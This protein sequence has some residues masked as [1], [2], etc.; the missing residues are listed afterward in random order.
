MINYNIKRE[1]IEGLILSCFLNQH[2]TLE[3]D[4]MEF[5]QYKLP[6]ELFKANN[7]HKM[8]AKAI[9]NLQNENKVVDEVLIHDYI[10]SKA[11]LNE[12]EYLQVHSYT[13]CSFDTM[14]SYL[15]MLE[16]LDKEEKRMELLRGL[17]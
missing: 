12:E 15:K 6:F 13:W 16:D 4:K 17:R 10:T 9:Y 11:K 14:L 8:I 3:L 2:R 1:H 5:E 7:T